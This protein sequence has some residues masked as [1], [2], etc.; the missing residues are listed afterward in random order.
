MACAGWSA[1]RLHVTGLIVRILLIA[2]G[3]SLRGD[4]GAAEVVLR[5]IAPSKDVVCRAVQQLTP[6]L[7]EDLAGYDRVVF[8]DADAASHH[9]AIEQVHATRP[10]HSVLTHA[11]TATEIV[12]MARAL[13]GFAGEALVCGIPARDFQA[14]ASLSPL[15][16]QFVQEAATQVA[17]LI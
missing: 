4:D 16:L 3:N 8:L 17:N 5:S 7:A 13:F 12:T 9:L 15:T 10:A 11:S 6:E 14:G 2:C 1:A